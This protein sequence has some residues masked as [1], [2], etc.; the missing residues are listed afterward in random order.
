MIRIELTDE[1]L[2]R[3]RLALSPLWELVASL[4]WVHKEKPT[5]EYAPWVARTR[6]ALRGVEL[7]PLDLDITFPRYV[8]D[9]AAH[10]GMA[11]LNLTSRLP[12]VSPLMTKSWIIEPLPWSRTTLGATGSPRS[13]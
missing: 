9:F 8:P 5:P 12:S 6:R 11:I 10:S 4:F 1:D 2:G 3:T 7:G 13:R